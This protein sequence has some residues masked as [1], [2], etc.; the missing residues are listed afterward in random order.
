MALES[1]DPHQTA[2]VAIDLQMRIVGHAT[3]PHTGADVVRQ[4]MRLTE[5]FRD[6]G[7]QVVIV[8]YEQPGEP[9][10]AGSEL[11]SEMEPRGDDLLITKHTWG[12][13]HETGLHEALR[14]RGVTTIALAGLATNFGV[15]STARAAHEL[16][17]R[18]LLVEDAMAGLD[19]DD[20]AFAI[21]R[22]FPHLG[23][24]CSTD[25]L[26]GALG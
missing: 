6:K 8:R 14:K 9:Q 5:A 18:V 15:E 12:A 4:C 7:G 26:L 22:I 11:V 20:H 10:P 23:T 25:E 2:F 16:G 3:A 19:A 1:I 24:V 13:F 17:Y 21:T